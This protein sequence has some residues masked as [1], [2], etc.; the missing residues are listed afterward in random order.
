M[1]F[2]WR[3]NTRPQD[4]RHLYMIKWTDNCYPVHDHWFSVLLFN[5]SVS[6]RTVS[7]SII[8]GMSDYSFSSSGPEGMWPPTQ[9]VLIPASLTSSLSERMCI[10]DS[11]WKAAAQLVHPQY[12]K[13]QSAGCVCLNGIYT[14][15]NKFLWW[16]SIL[17]IIHQPVLYQFCYSY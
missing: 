9:A 4:W 13:N 11:A 6:G 17:T 8:W 2:K 1:A 16:H 5:S 7:A 10:K 14:F 12:I 15:Y 3:Q